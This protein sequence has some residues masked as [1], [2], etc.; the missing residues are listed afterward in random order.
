[1]RWVLIA[2]AAATLA[3]CNVWGGD[4]TGCDFMGHHHAVGEVF[5]FDC[6]TCTCKADGSA[7]CTIIACGPQPDANPASCAH[8]DVCGDRGPACG[9]YC[10]DVG[11]RCVNDACMCGSN[12]GCGSG[13]MCASPGAQGS[14]S[15]GS[16]CCGASGPCPL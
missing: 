13:D 8:Q 1:M 15:C 2:I 4:K 10:C 16:I 6:N 5:P 7:T 11:E 12:P 9:A 14:D 3:G